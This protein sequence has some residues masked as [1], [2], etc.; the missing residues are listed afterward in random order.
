M[1]YYLTE[2]KVPPP[3]IDRW[4]QQI[5]FEYDSNKRLTKLMSEA[6]TIC[7]KI[8][9]CADF[10]SP[11]DQTGLEILNDSLALDQRLEAWSAEIPPEWSHMSQYLMSHQNRPSWSRNLFSGPGTP[12]KIYSYSNCLAASKWNLCRAT[13]IRLNLA[14]LEFLHRRQFSHSDLS[15]LKIRIVDLLLILIAEIAYTIP[16]SLALSSDGSS[17]FSSEDEIP[18][19][20]GYMV[21]WP[22]YT[23]FFCL[24]HELIKGKD[25]Q[26]RGIWFRRILNF[27]HESIGIAKLQIL[28]KE[29]ET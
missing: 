25:T 4:I 23:S 15:A 10:Q 18:T 8:W 7:A 6:A 5:P 11:T 22:A 19:L 9:D 1:V 16:S 21:L 14:L 2:R 17:D 27:L 13:R 3:H 26:S 29:I 28:I 12:E 24:H 20:W